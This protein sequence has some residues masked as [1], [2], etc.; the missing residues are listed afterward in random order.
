MELYRMVLS[1]H[2]V[3]P[4][5]DRPPVDRANNFFP[6][7]RPLSSARS[8]RFEEALLR[9]P[10]VLALLGDEIASAALQVTNEILTDHLLGWQDDTAGQREQCPVTQVDARVWIRVVCGLLDQLQVKLV[11]ERLLAHAAIHNGL[12]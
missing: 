2:K 6:A 3:E 4:C 11:Q 8:L 7:R 10:G 9:K 5:V 1:V 12:N